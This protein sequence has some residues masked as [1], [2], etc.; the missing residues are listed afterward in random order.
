MQMTHTVRRRVCCGNVEGALGSVLAHG[1]FCGIARLFRSE[2]RLVASR[3]LTTWD[4]F[5]RTA[6]RSAHP[7][8]RL[9]AGSPRSSAPCGHAPRSLH[10]PSHSITGLPTASAFPSPTRS[11][12][13]ACLP[14]NLASLSE[15][16]SA[17]V[18]AA[19]PPLRPTH[20]TS[21][22]DRPGSSPSTV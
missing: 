12:C 1:T 13:G 18:P 19:L 21:L 2:S 3:I 5:W 16:C 11:G 7:G 6:P 20:N 14:T 8:G 10:A 9:C 15:S 4:R 22:I 17:S